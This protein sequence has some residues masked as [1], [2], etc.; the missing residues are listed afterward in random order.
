MS[1]FDNF[2][3]FWLNI[4]LKKVIFWLYH[5]VSIRFSSVKVIIYHDLDRVV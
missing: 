3:Q 1:K 4:A 2:L 5:R